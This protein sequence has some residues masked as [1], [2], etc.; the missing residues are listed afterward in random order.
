MKL[1]EVQSNQTEKL[2]ETS[3]EESI[4]ENKDSVSQKLDIKKVT[5]PSFD[6]TKDKKSVDSNIQNTIKTQTK[7]NKEKLEK[8]SKKRAEKSQVEE[9]VEQTCNSKSKQGLFLKNL[10]KGFHELADQN[11]DLA[12]KL[13]ESTLN[14]RLMSVEKEKL[15]IVGQLS[16]QT[17]FD[18]RNENKT[19]KEKISKLEETISELCE[20]SLKTQLKNNND[21]FLSCENEHLRSDNLKLFEMLK[22][23][24]EYRKFAEF[25][26]F[27]NRLRFIHSFAQSNEKIISKNDKKSGREKLDFV[28]KD[29]D[30]ENF[31]W[32]PEKSFQFLRSL[33]KNPNFC[34]PE[35]SIEYILLELNKIW[36]KREIYIIQKSH[37]FCKNCKSKIQFEKIMDRKIEGF[38]SEKN[39]EIVRLESELAKTKSRLSSA[40][41]IQMNGQA[42]VFRF[43]EN[44]Q[45]SINLQ[46]L[47]KLDEE[48]KKLIRQNKFLEKMNCV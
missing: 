22:S 18:L 29:F 24:Q 47:R 16:D 10:K 4:S 40:Q 38:G 45:L 36:R 3:E 28:G 27:E 12:Q 7:Q 32:V 31:L 34:V 41:K 9:I 42:A 2:T 15:K 21:A 33:A 20:N 43:Q 5:T 11:R 19:L 35:K 44:Q 17:V 14:S 48:K 26:D 1:N 39:K 25:T 13:G 6:L 8:S 37:A 30:L 46:A 23:T